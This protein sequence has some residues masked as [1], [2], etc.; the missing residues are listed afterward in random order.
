M[1]PG[2]TDSRP[3]DLCGGRLRYWPGFIE[4]ERLQMLELQA[5]VLA[6]LVPPLRVRAKVE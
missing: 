3:L 2:L 1:L 6:S 4:P 5:G